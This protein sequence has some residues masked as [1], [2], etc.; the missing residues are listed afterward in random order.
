MIRSTQKRGRHIDLNILHSKT[1]A[2]IGS[3]VESST[4]QILSLRSPVRSRVDYS[5]FNYCSTCN[6]KLP[7]QTVRCPDCKQATSKNKAMAPLKN[8]TIE[9]N[10]KR[11]Y[12]HSIIFL[13]Q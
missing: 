11:C 5:L 9:E 10:L 8:H 1:T 2:T 4:S 6:V 7:K 3:I 13:Y 12:G